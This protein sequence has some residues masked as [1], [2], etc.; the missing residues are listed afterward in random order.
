MAQKVAGVH[1]ERHPELIQV[2][3]LFSR[4]GN[5]LTLHMVKEEKY[6]SRSSKNWHRFIT[7][8]DA[9]VSQLR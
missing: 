2:A 8:G 3:D 4:I 1:G 5:D 9:S 6:C 7:P